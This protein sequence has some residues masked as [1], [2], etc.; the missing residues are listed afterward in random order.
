MHAPESVLRVSRLH[1]VQHDTFDCGVATTHMARA[2]AGLPPVR[3]G[4]LMHRLGCTEEAGTSAKAIEA[5]VRQSAIPHMVLYGASMGRM[6]R[7]LDEGRRYVVCYQQVADGDVLN[8]PGVYTWEQ[9]SVPEPCADCR[10]GHY[11]IVIGKSN[12]VLW[13]L[14]PAM[15]Y[16]LDGLP[17][18]IRHIPRRMLDDRWRD[19]DLVDSG[20]VL[21][22]WA[23]RSQ[24]SEDIRLFGYPI[25]S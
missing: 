11:S 22:H 1:T 17:R 2:I 25:Y 24:V 6:L 3:Y 19:I 14:D 15:D 21:E 10:D 20:S 23:M 8:R 4:T 5:Y 7:G 18:G 9:S 12:T 16:A 13:V